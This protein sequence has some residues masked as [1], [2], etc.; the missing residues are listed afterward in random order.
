M[1]LDI[2]V[3]GTP[4]LIALG[5]HI[6]LEYKEAKEKKVE[7]M[8]KRGINAW[9][10][11]E[12]VWKHPEV[13]EHELAYFE[14]VYVTHFEDLTFVLHGD[15]EKK[16]FSFSIHRGKNTICRIECLNDYYKVIWDSYH[17]VSSRLKNFFESSFFRKTLLSSIA[18]NCKTNTDAIYNEQEEVCVR[19][20]KVLV[21]I[22]SFSDWGINRLVKEGGQLHITY[23][24]ETLCDIHFKQN[25]QTHIEFSY[26]YFTEEQKTEIMKTIMNRIQ[27]YEREWMTHIDSEDTHINDITHKEESNTNVMTDK[28]ETL[29]EKWNVY[30]KQVEE[31]MQKEKTYIEEEC[32][33]RFLTTYPNDM[34]ELFDSYRG[35]TEESQ[36]ELF[37]ELW[38]EIE[39]IEEE[40]NHIVK[41]IEE[42]KKREVKRK[43]LVLKERG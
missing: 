40:W 33:H 6:G 37:Q 2:L 10:R 11:K 24:K 18:A 29:R 15:V 43:L 28:E 31:V 8:I 41:N 23:G 13:F 26:P 9:A 21:N 22:R 32:V 14:N 12:L 38:N 36:V 5:G 19:Y 34:K 42:N 7:M 27:E 17:G 16:S 35:L 39:R 30:Q 20:R 3:V 4:I 1:L 25:K